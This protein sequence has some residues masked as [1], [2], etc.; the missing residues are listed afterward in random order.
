MKSH[1]ILALT[2][3]DRFT[4]E[5]IAK[6][7]REGGRSYAKAAK[8]LT[9]HK[10]GEVSRQLARHWVMTLDDSE[11]GEEVGHAQQVMKARNQQTSNNQLRRDVRSLIEYIENNETVVDAVTSAVAGINKRLPYYEPVKQDAGGKPI[12]VEILLSDLQIGKLA[13]NYTT[14]IALARLFEF[15]RAAIF[16]IQQKIAAGYRVDRIVLALLGDIIESDKKHKNSARATDTGTAE[17]MA[18]AITGLFTLIIEPLARLGIRLDVICVTGNHDHDDHGLMMY[19]PGLEQ[20]SFPIYTTLELVTRRSGYANVHFDI[21]HGSFATTHF[22]GQHALYEHGVGVSVTEAS[23]KAHKVK[24]GE[25][26]QRHMTY[27]RMGDKHNVSTFNAGQYVVNG[28]FFG[29][30]ETGSEYSSIAGF[31]GKPAQWLGFH[32][33]RLDTRFTL[34]DSFVVQLG[35]VMEYDH[36]EETQ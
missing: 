20:L 31:S 23:M 29:D 2:L 33:P 10:R 27:F 3:R 14:P 9:D 17:Q 6:A 26:V 4:R 7:Y 25:Q 35:H 8:I 1:S 24:R 18:N 21:P 12:T 30:D 22:Y 13:H 34:Y 36:V 19:K 28:A 32:V 16:Q 5:E 11:T 15:G